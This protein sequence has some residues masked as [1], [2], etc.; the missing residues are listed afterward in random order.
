MLAS[1]LSEKAILEAV[2][3]GDFY[4]ST[5]VKL[6]Q[7]RRDREQLQIKV[8]RKSDR[9]YRTVFFGKGGRVLARE[10]GLEA[11]YR[12]RPGDG[13]VRATVTDS[14]GGKAWVQPVFPAKGS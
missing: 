14:N 11:I 4:A 13:Y 7:L 8:A 9:Q 5:G 12:L 10:T 2:G 1:D 6:E 3:R